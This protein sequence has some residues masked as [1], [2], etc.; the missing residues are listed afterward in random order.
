MYRL[1]FS[2]LMAPAAYGIVAAGMV[3]GQNTSFGSGQS[4]PSKVIRIVASEAGSVGDAVARAVALGLASSTSQQ[5]V[6]DNRPGGVLAGD[7]VAKAAP[8]GYT[9]LSYGKKANESL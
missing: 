5:A 8:D 9:M 3:S 2:V 7:F 1:K 6:V 4:Y